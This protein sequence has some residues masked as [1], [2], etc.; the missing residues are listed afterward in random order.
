[1]VM[2]YI[3][4]EL[5]KSLVD[6]LVH[7]LSCGHVLPVVASIRQYM[8]MGTLDQ[9]HIRHFVTEVCIYPSMTVVQVHVYHKIPWILCIQVEKIEMKNGL[10][11]ALQKV[12]KHVPLYDALAM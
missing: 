5:K 12:T 8:E 1:M 10:G 9:S 7:L 3:Q 2:L 11:M 6:H 4:M